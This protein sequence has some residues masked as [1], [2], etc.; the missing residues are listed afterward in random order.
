[1]RSRAMGMAVATA[2][3]GLL[4]TGMPTGYAA[5]AEPRAAVQASVFVTT[6]DGVERLHQRPSVT[7]GP[8]RSDNP[9][10]VINP[11]Q[12]YQ[13]MDGF[14]ASITDSS[15]SVLSGLAP[16]VRDDTMSKLF[17]PVT[18]IGVSFL[19]QPVGSSDFTASPTHYTYD[20]VAPGQTDI[21]LSHFT[22]GHDEAQILPLLRQ[23]KALNH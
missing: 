22:I 12:T 19:R 4:A 23:A 8:G 20:D 7:F 6:V 1:M 15:A 18:G 16:A 10:I 21:P 5:N 11:D 14:G 3:A 17:D 13:S 2:T 9:T